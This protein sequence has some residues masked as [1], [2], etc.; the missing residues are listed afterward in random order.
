MAAVNFI[1]PIMLIMSLTNAQDDSTGTSN[2]GNISNCIRK[3]RDLH[4]YVL[5]NED[6]IDSLTEL[7]FETGRTFTE[8]VRITYKFTVLLPVDNHSSSNNATD[9]DDEDSEFACIDSQKEFIW[10][11]SALYLLGPEPLFWLTL[12]A[13][14]VTES[15]ITIHLPCLCSNAYDDL[16]SRLTYLVSSY[17]SKLRISY[18]IA[19]KFGD[20]RETNCP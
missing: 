18:I 19:G 20:L 1:I 11:S 9:Y 14:H 17:V 8:F 13:V 15:G 4:S 10:S 12:F 16:L 2:Y 3:Y 5:R 6:L 7:Y